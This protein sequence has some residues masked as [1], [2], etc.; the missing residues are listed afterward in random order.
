MGVR[1]EKGQDLAMKVVIKAGS[2]QVRNECSAGPVQT[3]P[4]MY[5]V[6][7]G[8]FALFFW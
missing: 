8:C 5:S 3:L 1:T 2:P 4:A 7:R 6:A